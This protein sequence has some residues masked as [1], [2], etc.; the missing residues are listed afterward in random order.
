MKSNP[1]KYYQGKIVN[2][3][4]AQDVLV[5]SERV[6]KIIYR[7]MYIILN[8]RLAVKIQQHTKSHD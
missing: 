1:Q 3:T 5:F 8:K 6:F 7:Y 4:R 2:I